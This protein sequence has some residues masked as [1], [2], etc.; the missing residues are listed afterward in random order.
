MR[1]QSN[2]IDKASRAPSGLGDAR[3]R[4]SS[5]VAVRLRGWRPG[6]RKVDLTKTFR[7]GG[8]RLSEAADLTERFVDGETVEVQLGQFT[9]VESARR[10]LTALGV[11]SVEP[12]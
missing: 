5:G 8:T 12:R 9:S 3:R 6:L 1:N 11:E 2:S 10:A 7:D 4:S